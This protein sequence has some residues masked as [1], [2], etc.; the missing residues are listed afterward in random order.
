MIYRRISCNA[1]VIRENIPF[2]GDSSEFSRAR[3]EKLRDPAIF[4]W[5]IRG[6]GR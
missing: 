6:P 3:D 1:D 4:D 5:Q 2:A